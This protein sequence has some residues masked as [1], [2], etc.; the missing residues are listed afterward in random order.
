MDR[1]T[2]SLVIGV[3]ALII[4]AAVV[5]AYLYLTRFPQNKP[6]T[7]TDSV[8][9][10]LSDLPIATISPTLGTRNSTSNGSVP[11]TSVGNSKIYSGPGFN[12]A[13]PSSWALLTCSNSQNFELDPVN[14]GDISGAV[15]DRAIKPVTFLVSDKVSCTG[16]SVKLGGN[17][18]MRSKTATATGTNYRW[19][20]QVGSKGLDI[21]HRVSSSGSRATSREDFSPQIEQ[22]I[23]NIRVGSGGS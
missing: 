20:L 2:K 18:V 3:F 21:S 14:Q 19:C 13:Y 11:G 17:Q 7:G 23:S 8:P 22:I 1:R 5:G 16:E 12:F 15:C 10:G 6:D 4:V 9:S